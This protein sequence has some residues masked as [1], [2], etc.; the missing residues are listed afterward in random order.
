LTAKGAAATIL[1]PQEDRGRALAA[2]LGGHTTFVRTDV[3]DGD[4]VLAAFDEATGKPRPLWIAVNCAGIGVGM[5]TA[6]RVGWP[7]R[8]PRV[9][10]SA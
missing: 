5:R 7:A 8:C 3:T 1:D 10:S 9:A 2:E 4:S 6:G